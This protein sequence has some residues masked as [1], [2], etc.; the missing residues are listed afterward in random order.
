LYFSGFR[1]QLPG[2]NA[3]YKVIRALMKEKNVGQQAAADGSPGLVPGRR[4]GATSPASQSP[5]REF[6]LDGAVENLLDVYL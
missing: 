5:D 3:P 4:P 6:P 2:K 1:A